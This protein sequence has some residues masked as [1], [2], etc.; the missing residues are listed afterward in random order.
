MLYY[1]RDS[2]SKSLDQIENLYLAG[3]N[4]L[5]CEDISFLTKMTN[6]KSLDISGNIDMYKPRE[7]LMKEA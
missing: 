7:M 6:L 1:A 3:K 4:L 5:L 2:G